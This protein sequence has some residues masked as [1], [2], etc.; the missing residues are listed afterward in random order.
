[1]PIEEGEYVQLTEDQIQNA[2]E[3]ELQSEFG[4]NID[5]TESSVFSTLAEVLAAV[6]SNNQEQS[7]EEVY[8]S[9]FIETATGADLDRVVALLGLQRRDAVHAT[10]V[11]RFSASGKVEQDYVVQ[12]GTAVQTLGANPVEFETTEPVTLELFNSF[13]DGDLTEFSGDVASAS[14]I[15]TNA[16]QGD[17]ALQMDA[18][19][20]AHIYDDSVSVDQGTRLHGHVRPQTGTVPILTFAVQPDDPTDYYQIA[21]DIANSQV[22]L[23][24]VVDGVV[25]STIDTASVTMSASTYYEADVNWNIT[26][27]IGVSVKDAS[28]SELATLGGVDNTY[29]SGGYGFKSGDATSTKVFDFYTTSERSADIRAVEGGP[30]GNLGSNSL[31]SVPS[32]PAG[33]NSVTNLYATGDPSYVDTSGSQFRVGENEESDRELRQRALNAASG[34]G[35]A[36]HDAMVGHLINSIDSVSSVTLFENKT[37][38]DNTG[39][40]GLPPT[41]FEAVVFGG[42]DAEVAE[43]IF[44]KKAVTAQ[45]YAGANGTAVTQTVVADSNGQER[46]IDFSRPNKVN[47]DM[48]LDLVINDNYIGDS[49]L[50]DRIVRYIGGRLSNDSDTVGLGVGENVILDHVRDIV[51]GGD[52]TGVKAFDNS[53]DGDPL[54]TSPAATTVDGIE[55][56]DI[57][58]VEVAQTDATDTSIT[59]NTREQ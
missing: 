56:I 6:I 1:M 46:D 50:R 33:V 4:S 15:N 38:T 11:E 53:V 58:S 9:A 51:V 59:L 42:G 41:S 2:L 8:K 3:A 14:I 17:N 39:T 49:E 27:N 36:T 40:G 7:L 47:V 31:Q 32:P 52:D 29:T 19:S 12:K 16:Y 22:R 55:V 24:T 48:T 37:D 23:E 5:L 26:D 18:T 28:G 20:G 43:A 10:G 54:S 30:E 13:E 57:G 44:E 45:D 25:S 21:F 35:S 34:G